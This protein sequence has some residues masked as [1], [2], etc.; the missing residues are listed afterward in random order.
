MRN[1]LRRDSEAYHNDTV[2]LAKGFNLRQH[3]PI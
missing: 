3:G 1:I 2:G